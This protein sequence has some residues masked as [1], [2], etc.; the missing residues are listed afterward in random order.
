MS[1]D[2]KLKLDL[3]LVPAEGQPDAA[4]LDDLVRLIRQGIITAPPGVT[5]PIT[6]GEFSKPSGDDNSQNDL[7]AKVKHDVEQA[8]NA[9]QGAVEKRAEIAAQPDGDAKLSAEALE[10]AQAVVAA[11]QRAMIRGIAVAVPE[12]GSEEQR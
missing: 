12:R 3:R 9:S 11:V 6:G 1:E 7:E 10:A 5:L 4:L 8:S 2:A